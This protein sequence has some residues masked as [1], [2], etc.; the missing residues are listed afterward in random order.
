MMGPTRCYKDPTPGE[1]EGRRVQPFFPPPPTV[2]TPATQVN[3]NNN[4]K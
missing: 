1:L 2:H 4:K 3:I